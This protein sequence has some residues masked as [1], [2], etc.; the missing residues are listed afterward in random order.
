M[1]V[2][3]TMDILA[4]K[5]ERGASDDQTGQEKISNDLILGWCDDRQRKHRIHPEERQRSSFVIEHVRTIV[6]TPGMTNG[7]P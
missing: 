1:V 4:R 3:T 2:Q 7:L 5:M 6:D